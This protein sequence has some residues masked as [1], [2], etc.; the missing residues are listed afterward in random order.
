MKSLKLFN[1]SKRRQLKGKKQSKEQRRHVEN[2]QQDDML[3]SEHVSNHIK[4]L[5]TSVKSQVLRNLLI[6]L[7]TTHHGLWDFSSPTR[8]VAQSVKNLPAMRETWIRSLGWEDPLEEGMATHPR[9]LA[10]R[11][12]MDREAWRA[13]VHGVTKSQTQL[14]DQAQHSTIRHR[15]QALTVT[16]LTTGL[17]GNSQ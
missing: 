15:T 4:R 2:K 16:A 3:K 17:P 1:Y 11:I 6:F 7:L 14:C 13:T 9:I 5:N 10:Q 12:P 8:D